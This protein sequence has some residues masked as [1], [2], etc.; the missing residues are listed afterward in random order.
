M[1]SARNAPKNIIQIINYTMIEPTF[2]DVSG[3]PS[4]FDLHL[5]GLVRQF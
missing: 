5:A 4:P 2:K 1:A 3:A